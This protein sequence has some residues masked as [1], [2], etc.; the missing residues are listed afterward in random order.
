MLGRGVV[1]SLDMPAVQQGSCTLK[2]R[3]AGRTV[4]FRN[5][6]II[7]TSNLGAMDLLQAGISR[8]GNEYCVFE[9]TR[10]LDTFNMGT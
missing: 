10:R 5:V 8:P 6:V 2:K 4:D 3:L 1:F 7:M 9:C